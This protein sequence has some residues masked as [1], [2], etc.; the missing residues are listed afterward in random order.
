MHLHTILFG[1]CRCSNPDNFNESIDPPDGQGH[2]FVQI[3]KR[4][5]T[6][7]SYLQA[8]RRGAFVEFAFCEI[9]IDPLKGRNTPGKALLGIQVLDGRGNR[10]DDSR[11]MGRNFNLW[12]RGLGLGIA[13]ITLVTMLVQFRRLQSGRK[14]SYDEIGPYQVIRQPHDNARTLVF[15]LLFLGVLGMALAQ[16]LLFQEDDSYLD[17]IIHGPFTWTHNTTGLS[18]EFDEN[19]HWMV[20]N[21]EHGTSYELFASA[22]GDISLIVAS[23]LIE[24]YSLES[25]GHVFVRNGKYIQMDISDHGMIDLGNRPVWHGEGT[26]LDIP[27]SRLNVHI[28]VDPANDSK[29]WRII[30]I[31]GSPDQESEAMLNE[32]SE[33]L[34]AAW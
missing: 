9:R 29:F 1:G 28:S 17:G 2:S 19:W 11:Y 15:S 30:S 32:M 25:Y 26:F 7:I 20:R 6:A 21:N 33:R 23:E 31:Q 10:L 14:T 5:R 27:G 34:L 4:N 8:L 18:V 22:V 16:H 12:W 3:A 13:F 24:G